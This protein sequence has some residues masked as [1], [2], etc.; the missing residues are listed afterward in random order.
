MNLLSVIFGQN[1]KRSDEMA[2]INY[3][4]Y[5]ILLLKICIMKHEITM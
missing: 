3:M 2:N 4:C 1:I 5:E